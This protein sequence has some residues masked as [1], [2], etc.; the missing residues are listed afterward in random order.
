[1]AK[2]KDEELRKRRF[3]EGL[4]E[5]ATVGHAAKIAGIHRRTAYL[6]RDSD[7]AFSA[8]WDGAIETAIEHLEAT[9]YTKALTDE[10]PLR[11]FFW[12]KR[13]RPEYRDN[14]RIEVAGQIELLPAP[15]LLR[16]IESGERQ[17]IDIEP[18]PADS[19]AP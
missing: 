4:A 11:S 5:T 14:F 2:L 16:R 13:W 7:P 10:S 17:V 3:L 19:D 18:L 9:L 6:W 12:L 1:M 15:E 8:G